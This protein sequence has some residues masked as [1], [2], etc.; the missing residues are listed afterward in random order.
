MNSNNLCHHLKA[1]H[2]NILTAENQFGRSPNSVTLLVVSKTQTSES[3][4]TLWTCGQTAFGENYLQEALPKMIA[5]QDTQIVWHF[6][7]PIQHNKTRKIAEHFSWVHTVDKASIAQRLNDQRPAHLPPLNICIQIN[8]S[9]ENTKS[10]IFSQTEIMHLIQIIQQLP[11]LKLRGFMII[12]EYTADIAK[13]R[14]IFSTLRNLRDHINNTLDTL[15]MG[16][17]NDYIA[18]I[19]EGATIV[20]LGTALFG[21]RMINTQHQ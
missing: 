18:A 19:A 13:Q 11:R 8:I 6:I 12:P 21:A 7:G 4:R 5:L 17:S 9:Q 2:Q 20:R 1:I 16:M 14:Q 3:I 15:S 10:G